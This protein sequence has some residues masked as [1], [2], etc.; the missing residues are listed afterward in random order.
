[1]TASILP[2]ARPPIATFFLGRLVIWVFLVCAC[3]L[4]L[5][6]LTADRFTPAER[7]AEWVGT[8]VWAV[9]MVIIGERHWSSR[10]AARRSAMLRTGALATAIIHS[11]LAIFAGPLGLF[12]WFAPA[13][14][15]GSRLPLMSHLES[16]FWNAFAWTLVCGAQTAIVA[17]V[18]GRALGRARDSLSRRFGSREEW[19]A[20]SRETR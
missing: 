11:G 2:G 7:S 3:A 1:M 4:P 8:L 13:I 18:C 12:L 10:E 15:T 5:A 6:I 20:V 16:D 17:W 9:A 19:S 14:W